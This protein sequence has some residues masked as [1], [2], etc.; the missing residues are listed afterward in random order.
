MSL[1]MKQDVKSLVQELCQEMAELSDELRAEIRASGR[2]VVRH[3]Y[4]ALLAQTVMLLGF[5]YFFATHIR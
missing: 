3:M 4:G 2:R 1:A 5:A